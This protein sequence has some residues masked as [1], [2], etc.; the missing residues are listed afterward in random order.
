MRGGLAAA[1]DNGFEKSDAVFEKGEHVGP[2]DAVA[3][4]GLE[5][6]IVAIGASP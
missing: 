2:R 6:G 5:V 3:L 1:E 4:E